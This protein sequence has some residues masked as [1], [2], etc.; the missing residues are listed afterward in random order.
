[1]YE[2]TIKITGSGDKYNLVEALRNL[3]NSIAETEDL[4]DKTFEDPILC[5]ETSIIEQ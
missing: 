1:M 4:D 5:A 3:A 2:Y